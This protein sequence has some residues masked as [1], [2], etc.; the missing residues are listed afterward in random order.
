[1]SDLI[2]IAEEY[3]NASCAG[4]DT[5]YSGGKI[6]ENVANIKSCDIIKN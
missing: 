4:D 5:A 2:F 1:M 3:N 6:T